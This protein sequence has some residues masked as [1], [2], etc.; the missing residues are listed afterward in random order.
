MNY[1]KPVVFTKHAENEASTVAGS[2]Y[3]PSALVTD[4]DSQLPE[5]IVPL[6]DFSY[7]FQNL[8]FEQETN[9]SQEYNGA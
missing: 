9:E 1:I 3:V 8:Y 2:L 7:Q 6:L 5:H 4:Q